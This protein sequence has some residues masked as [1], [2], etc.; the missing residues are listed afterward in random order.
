MG[1]GLG[2]AGLVILLV[3]FV[4]P[5]YGTFITF[6]AL[7]LVAFGALAG[8]RVF[9]IAVVVVAAVKVFFLSPS[10]AIMLYAQSTPSD[11]R[12]AYLLL[13][14][15]FLALPIATLMVRALFGRREV[16]DV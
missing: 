3:S 14:V 1:K 10:W 7:V 11:S 8:D 13:T 12:Q 5:V 15:I 2:I 9:A 6:L 16:S 4:I